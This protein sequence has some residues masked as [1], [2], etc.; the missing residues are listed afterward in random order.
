MADLPQK[1]AE[2]NSQI[3]AIAAAIVG[4]EH[5]APETGLNRLLH[6]TEQLFRGHAGY[7]P[8]GLLDAAVAAGIHASLADLQVI[9]IQ[10]AIIFTDEALIQIAPGNVLDR[11]ARAE[12]IVKFIQFFR[13]DSSYTGLSE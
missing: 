10:Q 7:V 8:F 9:T 11:D 5:D 3:D 13:P 6:F 2:V 1:I 4:H 12:E